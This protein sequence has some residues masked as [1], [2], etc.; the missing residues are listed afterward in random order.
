MLVSANQLELPLSMRSL[1]TENS[2]LSGFL[3]QS[4]L[5]DTTPLTTPTL[6]EM[7]LTSG[8]NWKTPGTCW[9]TLMVTKVIKVGNGWV[10]G[11][12]IG[13]LSH[14]GVL[15]LR[16]LL[17]NTITNTNSTIKDINMLMNL[18]NTRLKLTTICTGTTILKFWL[19]T[20]MLNNLM[21]LTTRLLLLLTTFRLLLLLTMFRLLLLTLTKLPNGLIGLPLP[22]PDT[23]TETLLIGVLLSLIILV[24]GTILL[25]TLTRMTVLLTLTVNLLI[26]TIIVILM[27]MLEMISLIGVLLDK[28]PIWTDGTK[29]KE[30]G[31]TNRV[32]LLDLEVVLDLE[33]DQ[34][35]VL[36]LELDLVLD[37]VSV[38]DLETPNL[39]KST[40][41]LGLLPPKETL[42]GTLSQQ[43]E[44]DSLVH[45][46]N[47]I[48]DILNILIFY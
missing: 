38:L 34:V 13:M 3:S 23:L 4:L 8:E 37:Q 36:D 35:S 33:V 24:I 27:I 45:Q 9:V 11:W 47:K 46:T 42:G 39:M 26:L 40:K 44:T 30:T 17:L 29:D 22:M 32:I 41:E 15:M 5:R 12:A 10:T 18:T 31:I 7:T 14:L 20:I 16:P 19:L 2:R 1:A 25:I 43:P 28:I 6:R 48:I 21:V